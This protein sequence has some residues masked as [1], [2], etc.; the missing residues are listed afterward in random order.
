LKLKHT[1]IIITFLFCL[2]FSFKANAKHIIGGE[3][4]YVCNGNGSYSFTM[5]VYRDC[6]SDGAPYDTPAHISIYSQVG[7]LYTRVNELMVNISGGITEIAPPDDPCLIPPDN[8]CVQE[9]KY[10]FSVNLPPINGSYHVV[11]QRC[12]RNNTINNIV[13]P[14]DAGATYTVEI[15]EEAQTA[16]NNTPVYNDFPPILICVNNPLFFDHSASDPDGDQLVYE[17]CAPI[18][19]G[20]PFGT[21]ENPGDPS[22]CDGVMPIWPCAPPFDPVPY[23]LPTYSELNPMGGDPQISIDPNTGIITG[24]PTVLGQ[25]VVGV[26]VSEYRNGVLLSTVRRDFQFNV[27]S[28]EPIVDARVEYD[29]IISAQEFVINSCGN[30]TITFG[31]NSVQEENIDQFF[32]DFTINGNVETFTEWEPTVTFPG[33]GTYQGVLVLN[34]GLDCGDTAFINVNVYPNIEADFSFDYD[35]CVAGPVTFTDLSF[36]DIGPDGIIDWFW[37]FDL[38]QQGT[39]EE[40]NPVYMLNSPGNI[41]VSLTVTDSNGCEDTETQIVPWFPVPPILIIEPS[42]F[43]GCIPMEVFFNNLSIPIDSTYDIVWDFG[44]GTTSGEVSPTHI[45]TDPGIYDISLQVTSPIGCYIED[46]WPNWI[47]AKPSPIADFI[48]SP[49]EVNSF[50][51]T[52]TFTDLSFE[53][54]LWFWDFDGDGTSN[55]QNPVFTFPDTGRQEVMLIVTHE[56][57]CMD[58]LI[59]FLDVIPKVTFFMPNAFTPNNDGINDFFLGN[60]IV[61]GMENFSMLIWNRYGELIFETNNPT[62]SWNGRKRNTG[63][64]SPNGVYVYIVNYTGPRKNRFEL[65]GYATLIR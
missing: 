14:E 40:Q 58:T 15:T 4:T 65:K 60:G 36:S 27:T 31:N 29:E 24:T 47:V 63:R 55:V 18:L 2:I 26:C 43:D 45:Y 21:T 20:G 61:E 13:N 5:Y 53:P 16:C 57:G 37:N 62:E 48:Y 30:N 6:S 59:Q 35:T 50:D 7:N 64:E 33:V 17:F 46:S 25:F 10:I 41:P 19:G 52:A 32:W 42:N 23:V 3:I 28:C 54:S 39:S 11:Y 22:D 38:G 49:D 1:Y 44:D 12:C 9:A 34:P 8:I 56:S 51:P